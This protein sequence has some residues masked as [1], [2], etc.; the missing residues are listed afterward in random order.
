MPY[1]VKQIAAMSGVSVRALYFYDETRRKPKRWSRA[2]VITLIRG[3][4]ST[5]VCGVHAGIAEP[6]SQRVE[7]L[8]ATGCWMAGQ[9]VA[10]QPLECCH[11]MSLFLRGTC[12]LLV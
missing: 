4:A 3:V 6:V 7:K 12:Q 2:Q 1:T 5:A 9:G 8:I 11:P 10:Q